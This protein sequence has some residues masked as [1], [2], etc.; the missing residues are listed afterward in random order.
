MACNILFPA[1]LVC[2]SKK[3]SWSNNSLYLFPFSTLTISV[4]PDESSSAPPMDPAFNADLTMSERPVKRTR[5]EYLFLTDYT[6]SPASCSPHHQLSALDST[7]FKRPCLGLGWVV[8]DYRPLPGCMC[9]ERAC[10]LVCC[11][12]RMHIQQPHTL[13]PH[14]GS[15]CFASATDDS[16]RNPNYLIHFWGHFGFSW[17]CF[18]SDSMQPLSLYQTYPVAVSTHFARHNGSLFKRFVC[19]FVSLF[20][21]NWYNH[22]KINLFC[23]TSLW[24]IFVS[25]PG[26]VR[27]PRPK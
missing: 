10:G 11:D 26:S 5:L 14:T 6:T 27:T 18:F 9:E 21:C 4:D 23:F 3:A 16:Y 13:N 15:L 25:W 7:D 1:F 19:W 24:A 12:I 17:C 2:F 22:D 20:Y 8:V